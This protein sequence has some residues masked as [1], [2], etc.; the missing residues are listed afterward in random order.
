MIGDK[1]RCIEAGMDDYVSKPF[2]LD[3]IEEVLKKRVLVV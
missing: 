2:R 1:E 3:E